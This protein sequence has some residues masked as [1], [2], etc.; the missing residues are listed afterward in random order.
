MIPIEELKILK[1]VFRINKFLK[2]NESVIE[3]EVK[4]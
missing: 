3:M 1:L 2:F 4:T